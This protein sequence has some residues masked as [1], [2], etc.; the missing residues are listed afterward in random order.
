MNGQR[1]PLSVYY[2]GLPEHDVCVNIHS[3]Q[4]GY[5]SFK[6]NIHLM[7]DVEDLHIVEDV[8]FNTPSSFTDVVKTSVYIALSGSHPSGYTRCFEFGS[9]HFMCNTH[10]HRVGEASPLQSIWS[11]LP[12]DEFIGNSIRIATSQGLQTLYN[13][14][15]NKDWVSSN[16]NHRRFIGLSV[17]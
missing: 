12:A 6:D 11:Y 7:L 17:P 16:F 3:S 8:W 14:P 15:C 10:Y 1:Q 5:L 4:K 9:C 2:E 13:G